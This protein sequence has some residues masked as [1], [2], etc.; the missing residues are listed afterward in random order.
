MGV[1]NLR[2]R[3]H[4]HAASMGRFARAAVDAANR[5]QVDP[6][7]PSSPFISMRCGIATGPVSAGV[8]GRSRPRYCLAGNTVRPPDVQAVGRDPST[9][10][11]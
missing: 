7:V 2:Q 3:Q 10:R 8:M 6:K 1:A 4:N 11:P 9:T 5:T